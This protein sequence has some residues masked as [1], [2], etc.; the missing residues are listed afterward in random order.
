MN[1]NFLKLFVS[2]ETIKLIRIREKER[3]RSERVRKFHLEQILKR[4]DK[5]C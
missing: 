5:E 4:K 1:M 3:R 2:D